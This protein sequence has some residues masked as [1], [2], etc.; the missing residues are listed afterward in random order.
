MQTESPPRPRWNQQCVKE[1]AARE[2]VDE[3]RMWADDL[4]LL[5]ED[6]DDKEFLAVL[7]LALIES[8]D[9]YHAGRYLED[10][11]GWPVNGDLI[12]VLDRAFGRMKFITSVFVQQWVVKHNVRM[13]ANKGDAIRCKIGDLELSGRMVEVIKREARGIFIPNGSDR[14]MIVL[15][16]EIIQILPPRKPKKKKD[17]V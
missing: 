2:F 16:E 4:G 10:F 12:R 9:A 11:I 1:A 17:T 3:V 13:R 14:H 15:A 5:P 8:P 6:V 7:A